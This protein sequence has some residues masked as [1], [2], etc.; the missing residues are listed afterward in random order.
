MHSRLQ[1]EIKQAQ[2]FASLEEEV[3][4]S[5]R[6]TSRLL[7]EPWE[8]HLKAEEGLTPSQYN[9][10]RILRGAHPNGRTCTEIAERMVNRDPD[11]TRLVDRMAQQDL[12]TRERDTEDRRVVRVAITRKGLAVLK[13]LDEAVDLFP[14]KVLVGH[15]GRRQLRELRELLSAIRSGMGRFP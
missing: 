6:L 14:R 9:L 2:P 15:M 10:L 7:D 5:L 12:V 11:V 13:R 1:Q 8:R 4:L 3:Y